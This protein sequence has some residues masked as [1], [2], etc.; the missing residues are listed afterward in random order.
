MGTPVSCAQEILGG[1]PAKSFWKDRARASMHE[2][3]LTV[4][5]A[6]SQS[7]VT[8]RASRR[9]GIGVVERRGA[10]MF[11]RSALT[12]VLLLALAA[13][14]RGAPNTTLV[15]HSE[16]GRSID[17]LWDMLLL[18]GTIVFVLVEAA[19]LYVVVRFR[20]REGT[21][22]PK[23]VH[24]N[25]TLE[26][27]W[28]L[29]PAVVLAV[30]AV[31]TVRT[32]FRTQAPALPNALQVEVI[33]HQWWW[34]FRYPQYGV[35]TANELYLP[36]GRTVNFALKSAD[37]IHSFWIP[38]VSG[39]RDLV[40]NRTTYLWFTPDSA[41]VWNG[42]CAEYCGASHANMR[43]RVFTVA[44]VRFEGWI[45]HQK[46]PPVWPA[47]GG[48]QPAALGEATFA[49][50]GLPRHSYPSTPIPVGLT[51]TAAAGD[52]ARG[53]ELYRTG[54]CV[55]C[56]VVQGI[57]AGVAGPNLTHVAS[58]ATIAGATYPNDLRHLALW[59][60]NAPA[61]KPG[62]RMPAFGRSSQRPNGYTDQQVAD[63][64]AYLLALK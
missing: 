50:T 36:V 26:V 45:A 48:G 18:A 34:E 63:I 49:V 24:G 7:P 32:I 15:P 61:M 23:Q 40:P 28:M 46:R 59:I 35:T 51:L 16:F 52:P 5:S 39:K 58:R 47:A 44:P 53:A 4:S 57:S 13:C 12:A 54:A 55:G 25:A 27:I 22:E 56:H 31:P 17:D 14:T 20:R 33:S 38:A 29:I 21:P 11:A 3:V 30:I 1:A 42:F 41:Y 43:F 10:H 8:V 2:R 62:S 60:K 37:V 64:A 19:L 9:H 6:S